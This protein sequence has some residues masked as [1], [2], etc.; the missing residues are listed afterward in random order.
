M[1]NLRFI[2]RDGKMVLQELVEIEDGAY[3]FGKV[4]QD[5]PTHKELKKAGVI[6]ELAESL[7]IHTYHKHLS[8]DTSRIVAKAAIEFMKQRMPSKDSGGVMFTDGYNQAIKDVRK[9]LFG[10]E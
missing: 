3:N 7:Y 8:Y 4:W 6:E 10:E 9:A 5:V 1:S 2:E